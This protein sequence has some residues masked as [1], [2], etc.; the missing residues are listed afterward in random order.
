M[1]SAYK[2][3]QTQYGFKWQ[4][5]KTG[6][7]R[8]WERL[9]SGNILIDLQQGTRTSDSHMVGKDCFFRKVGASVCFPWL[10]KAQ[11][12]YYTWLDNLLYMV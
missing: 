4:G 3:G 7:D 5:H 9:R 1:A 8:L 10:L 2:R 11:R 6:Q 12:R